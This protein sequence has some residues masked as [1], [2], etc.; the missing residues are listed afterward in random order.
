MINVSAFSGL[1]QKEQLS[2]RIIINLFKEGYFIVLK[3]SCY[4]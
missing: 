3:I 2:I 4:F 1:L